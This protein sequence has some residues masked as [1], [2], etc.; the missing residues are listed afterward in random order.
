MHSIILATVLHTAIALPAQSA[1]PRED[2]VLLWNETTLRAIRT[3]KTP[4]PAAARHL[5]MV[6]AAI[7]DSVNSVTRTHMAYRA[8]PAAA[9][10]TS[11]EAAAAVAAHCV[12][13][14]LYPKQMKQ[15]DRVLDASLAPIT[16]G[17][18]K[19]AGITLGRTVAEGMLAWRRQDGSTRKET[20]TLAHVP[21]LWQPTP[22][23]Y[24]AALLPRWRSVMPF[25]IQG[26]RQFNPRPTPPLKSR[27]YTA[28][29]LEVKAVGRVDSRTR[30]REQTEIAYFWEDGVG[31]VTPPGHWN[32]IAQG[33]SRSY[34]LNLA[35]NARLFALLNLSLADAAILCWEC[36]YR[37]GF[38]R[39][40]QAIPEADQDGNPDTTPDRDWMP[41]L[42]TPPFPTYS[43]GHSTFSGTGAAVLASFFGT[44]RVS[45]SST[46]EGLPG[47]ARSFNGF[48]TAAEEAGMSRIYGGIHWQ[49]DNQ[50]GLQ[51][52]K[53]LGNYV[54]RH[55][56]LPVSRP[57]SASARPAFS[58]RKRFLSNVR[59]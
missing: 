59:P 43:S 38:W 58:L 50:E 57:Y 25:A 33:V 42:P 45:F 22:P 34:R 28:S 10:G 48:W 12:L 19:E 17:A 41:L 24:Q 18:G 40:V 7:Y 15:F 39:P 32:R 8:Q 27:E 4:P 35:E 53:A 11:P 49:F 30:T 47:V 14:T 3:A 31:T 37:F 5:A 55:F 20:Y 1:P 13:A 6:H 29:F 26:T 46:S 44:D 52:G 9:A 21:S 54:S 51:A 2:L 36:K 23:R 16:E 56:L